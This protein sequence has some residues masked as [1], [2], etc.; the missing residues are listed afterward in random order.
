MGDTRQLALFGLAIDSKLRACDPVGLRVRDVADG[1]HI[2]SRG[3][4]IQ[5]KTKRPVQF[6]ITPQTRD[7]VAAWIDSQKLGTT[8]YSVDQVDH[9]QC[10]LQLPQVPV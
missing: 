5:R 8:N 2:G 6:E 1:I 3:C 7:E 10:R 9:Q 4:A